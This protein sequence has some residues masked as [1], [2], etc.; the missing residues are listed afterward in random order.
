[1]LNNGIKEEVGGGGGCSFLQCTKIS[2]PT[3]VHL[4]DVCHSALIILDL[5]SLN[6]F[7]PHRP[8]QISFQESIPFKAVQDMTRNRYLSMLLSYRN[9][10]YLYRCRYLKILSSWVGTVLLLT[11]IISFCFFSL[12]QLHLFIP[13]SLQ[14]WL[15]FLISPPLSPLFSFKFTPPF[16]L[17]FSAICGKLHLPLKCYG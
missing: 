6:I 14:C 7:F 10:S 4:E 3:F 17:F 15:V 1:M 9:N 16:F 13:Y 11:Y 8:L 2:S 12:F 5:L